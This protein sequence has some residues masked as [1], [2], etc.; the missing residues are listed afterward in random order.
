MS[1]TQLRPSSGSGA[2]KIKLIV[3]T[4]YILSPLGLAVYRLYNGQSVDSF[5]LVIVIMFMVASGYVIF[6]EKTI[7][8]AQQTA[9]EI[10]GGSET[11]GEKDED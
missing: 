2:D 7:E 6:G 8:K 1:S 11:E 9:E 5:V 3:S 10:K 4:L